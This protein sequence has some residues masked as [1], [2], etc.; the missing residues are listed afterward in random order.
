MAQEAAEQVAFALARDQI[1]VADQLGAALAPLQHDLAAVERLQL[2]TM[3]DADDGCAG[4][5]G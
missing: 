1:D 5:R 3:G 2:D 4:L